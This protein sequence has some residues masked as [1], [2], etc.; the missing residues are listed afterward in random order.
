M[1]HYVYKTIL[2]GSDKYYIGRRS[3]KKDPILDNYL[4]SGKWVK[5]IK[6]KS[7]LSK[8]I[9]EV[10]D[11]FDDL[12]IG[13]E[14]WIAEHFDDP[15]NMNVAC[16]SMGAGAGKNSIWYGK[17]HTYE[18]RKQMSNTRKGVNHPLYGKKHT[19]ESRKLMSSSHIGKIITEETCKRMSDAK[20]GA[21]HPLYGKK[22]TEE[23]KQR[24]SEARSGEKHYM[25]GKLHTEE[26]RKKMSDAKSGEKCRV[27]KLNKL[28]VLE[29]R[30]LWDAGNTSKTELGNVYAVTRRNIDYIV[31][32]K[33]WKHI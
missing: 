17:T 31:N 19:E 11:T 14:N 7:R 3:S 8:V 12:L 29:I 20:S 16:S 22:H 30:K 26:T 6:E 33:S 24:M 23:S 28:E 25:Y 5:S 10:F 21:N 15:N 27:A 1:N 4:G 32:R 13:E 9:L 18:T 2:E